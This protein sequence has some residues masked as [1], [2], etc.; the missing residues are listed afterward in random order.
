LFVETE[1]DKTDLKIRK[2]RL[3]IAV[4]AYRAIG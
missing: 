4:F 2:P 1:N 3:L